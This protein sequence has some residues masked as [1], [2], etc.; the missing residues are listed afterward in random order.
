MAYQ[1][2]T[3]TGYGD[4]LK[5]ALGGVVGGF[6]MFIGGTALLFWNEGNFVKTK[7]ALDEAQGPLCRS[8]RSPPLI[9]PS[10]AS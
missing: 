5:K 10:K 1:E 7:K 9:L 4:R 2:V 8:S 3:R 6:V